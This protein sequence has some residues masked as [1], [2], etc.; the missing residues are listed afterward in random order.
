[1]TRISALVLGLVA[2]GAVGVAV[3]MVMRP[4]PTD[5]PVS[6]LPASRAPFTVEDRLAEFGE[7]AATRLAPHFEAAGVAYPPA[8]VVLVGLKDEK[9]LQLYAR[10]A[11]RDWRWVRTYPVLAASGGPGPKLREGDLQVPEGLY[12]VEFLN[13]NSRYHVSLRVSYPNAFDRA[14]GA[15]DNRTQLG[16]DIMIH[17]RAVSVG[18]LAMGDPAAE[19]LFTLAAAVG[20]ENIRVILA[21]V[22]F[23][24]REALHVTDAPAWLPDLYGQLADE[25]Q[26]LPA[27]GR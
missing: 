16:G 5:D 17:G 25:L 2:A 4:G 18:C 24:V 1:M 6:D 27:A 22:D 12:G 3:V 13:A 8:A 7:A 23:R 14:R 21:P 20:R 11:Y 19:E 10:D 9:Q 15:E 26:K